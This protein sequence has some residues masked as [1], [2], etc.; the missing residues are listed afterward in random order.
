MEQSFTINQSL[1]TLN[2]YTRLNRTA[3]VVGAKAK[4][5]QQDII[6]WYLLSARL[7]PIEGAIHA[8]FYWTLKNRRKD[9]DNVAFAQKFIFDALVENGT[10][11]DDSQ[12]YLKGFSH[13]FE[14]GKEDSVK[15]ILKEI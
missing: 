8:E 6:H 5:E 4:K 15:V 14:I 9:I 11:K 1:M 3:F 7:A 13:Y 2:E 12:K 10:L